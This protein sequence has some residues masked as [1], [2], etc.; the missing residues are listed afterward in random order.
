MLARVD[1]GWVCGGW[2][3]AVEG[4]GN[5]ATGVVRVEGEAAVV[6]L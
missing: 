6:L 2:V 1:V 4:D 3:V 5:E